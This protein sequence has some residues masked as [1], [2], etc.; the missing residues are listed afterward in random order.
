MSNL[1]DITEMTDSDIDNLLNPI[2]DDRGSY[3]K[4][5]DQQ[6]EGLKEALEPREDSKPWGYNGVHDIER[7]YM[8]EELEVLLKERASAAKSAR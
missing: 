5:L 6:I 4:D 2:D 8:R 1:I 3:L 7:K